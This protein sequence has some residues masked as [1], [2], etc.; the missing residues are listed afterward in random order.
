MLK[1]STFYKL[2]GLSRPAM[3]ELYSSSN[4]I[5]EVENTL[6]SHESRLKAVTVVLLKF[7]MIVSNIR[8]SVM[9]CDGQR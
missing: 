3:G 5:R 1:A 8:E 2:Q 6:P 4:V 7:S 9:L